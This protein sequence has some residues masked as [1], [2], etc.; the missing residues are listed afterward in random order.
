MSDGVGETED[1]IEA[2]VARWNMLPDGCRVIV[3]LSGGADSVALT[4][5][6][7]RYSARHSVRVTAAHVNHGLRGVQSDEDERFVREFCEKQ[8]VELRVLRSDV[9]SLAAGKSEGIEEC[10]R[11]VRYSFFQSLCGKDDRIATAHT[12]SDSAETVLMNLARGAGPRGL[13]G[14]PPVRG[15]VVRPL[16]EI[17]R[18][19]VERYCA[20]Y[21]L[22][23]VTDRTNLVPDCVRNKIRLLVV[24]VM[25]EINPAFEGCVGRTLRLFR[26]D[27]TYL[28]KEAG[29]RLKE[30]RMPEG[31]RA[32]AFRDAPSPIESRMIFKA[33]G[34]RAGP[35]EGYR[36]IGAVLK[37]IAEGK[38]TV[39]VAG[40]IQCSV[41][42]NTLFITPPE[43]FSPEKAWKVPLNP[44]GTRLP[45]GRILTARAVLPEIGKK[46]GKIHNLRFYNLIDYD[47]IF[48]AGGFVRNRRPGD[49]FLLAGR[50]VTKTLK[51]LFNE[52][53]IPP[54][55]RDRIAVVEVAGRIVWVEGFGP[56]EEALP[57]EED[58]AAA[59]IMIKECNCGA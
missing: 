23:F 59:E 7:L 53:K 10:G 13:C 43:A 28:E 18:S 41:R 1:K 35:R 47:T 29:R 36:N 51:K 33:L 4:H 46:R 6:L 55:R 20:F 31:Y 26:E 45:D 32:A 56:S 21:G 27:E 34:G 40:G 50:G 39:T 48:K 12:L 30:A 2:A 54:W 14:V 25:K 17:T 3:G 44:S 15:N 57:S 19:E 8:G 5:F 42:G 16:I 11:E 49:R 38:G 22:S 52:T 24:P 58:A 37:V 9:R